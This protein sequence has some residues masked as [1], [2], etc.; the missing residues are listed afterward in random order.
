MMP[1]EWF[2]EHRL[3]YATRTLDPEDA[4]RFEAHLDG[5]EECRREIARIEQDLSWL[6]MGLPPIEPRPGFRRRVIEHVLESRSARSPRW[7]LPAALAASVFLFTAGWYLGWF[8]V[9]SLQRELEDQRAVVAA[10][11]DTLSIMRQAGRVLQANV[12]IGHTRG[13]V[14]IFA[15]EVTHR[16]NVVIHGLPPA[17]AGY[18]YQFWFVCADSMVRG[19]EVAADTLRPTM[20]T[21]GMPEQQTC[22]IV[23]GAALTEESVADA[24]GPP[25]GKSLAHLML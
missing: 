13:G 18:R 11:K 14:L 19:V 15:D 22:P 20:F 5:C 21:T 3:D 24:Q 10:L 8:R 2:I 9:G 4:K 17:A 12:E 23:K 7:L 6:P 1:H 16:W 25:R